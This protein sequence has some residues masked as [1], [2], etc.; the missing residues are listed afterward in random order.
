VAKVRQEEDERI[1][2]TV[3]NQAARDALGERVW[4]VGFRV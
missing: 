3:A 2:A 1:R 4:G